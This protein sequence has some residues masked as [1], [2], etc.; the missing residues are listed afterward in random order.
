M[1]CALVAVPLALILAPFAVHAGSRRAAPAS[2][3]RRTP[4]ADCWSSASSRRT[5]A[6]TPS[7]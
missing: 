6:R 4:P 7:W 3:W 2:P 5:T 1:A